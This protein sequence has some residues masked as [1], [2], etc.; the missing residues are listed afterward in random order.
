MQGSS[1]LSHGRSGYGALVLRLAHLL[2]LFAFFSCATLEAPK[3][4]PL[5]PGPEPA[6]KEQAVPGSDAL[7]KEQFA[8]GSVEGTVVKVEEGQLQVRRFSDSRIV[9]VRVRTAEGIYVGD[10][11]QVTEGVAKKLTVGKTKK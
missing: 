1:V 8:P 11:V 10:R 3:K 5:P 9:V 7:R 4:D 6:K 2:I